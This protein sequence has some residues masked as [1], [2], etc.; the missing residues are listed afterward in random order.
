MTSG[1]SEVRLGEDGRPVG[2]LEAE[3]IARANEMAEVVSRSEVEFFAE[4]RRRQVLRPRSDR[5]YVGEE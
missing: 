3:W 2:V 4:L 1:T 5:H